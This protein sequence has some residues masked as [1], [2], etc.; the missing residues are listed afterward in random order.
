MLA[1]LATVAKKENANTSA[2]V[3]RQQRKAGDF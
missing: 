3:F 2:K 1:L